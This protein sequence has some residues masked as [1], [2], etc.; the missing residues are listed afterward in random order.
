LSKFEEIFDDKISLIYARNNLSPLFARESF[1]ELEKKNYDKAIKILEKGIDAF[2]EYPV[3]YFILGRAY[4]LT[5]NYSLALRNIK[6]ASQLINSKKTY[7]YYLREIEKLRGTES[8]EIE[9]YEFESPVNELENKNPASVDERLSE[10]AREISAAKI[11]DLTKET[12]YEDKTAA[13]QSDDKM[14]VSDTLAKIYAAQGEINEA[15]KT[16]EK[17]MKKDPAKEDYYKERIAELKLKLG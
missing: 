6:T 9:K 10:I 16:Y 17:L 12:N 14:I 4:L 3:P 15:I 11:S 2:P 7:E 1:K 13:Y 8:I 5:G